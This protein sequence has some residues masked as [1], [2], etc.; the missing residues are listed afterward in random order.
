MAVGASAISAVMRYGQLHSAAAGASYTS[1]VTTA[2]RQ[3][4]TWASPTGAGSFSLSTPIVFAGGG[5]GNPVY[6]ITLWD[7]LTG[8]NC[9]GEF[10]FG[11]GSDSAFNSTGGYTVSA[12]DLTGSAS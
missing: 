3:P 6:S 4:I 2:A 7:S 9:Y 8:G 11:S 5:G 10:V 1:N 12:I